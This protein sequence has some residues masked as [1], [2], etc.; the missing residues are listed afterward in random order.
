VLDLVF[1]YL[2]VRRIPTFLKKYWLDI[3]AVFPFFL[4]FRTYELVAGA[5]SAVVSESAQT[6]QAVVHEGLELEKEGVKVA[7]E[8]EKVAKLNRS[9]KFMRFLRP[10]TRIPRF[11]K[12]KVHVMHFYD[13]PHGSHH[14]HEYMHPSVHRKSKKKK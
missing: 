3:L 7:K 13:K 12:A 10:I 4:V 8:V 11:L 1:K 14:E 9:Q 5:F 6:V 2:R